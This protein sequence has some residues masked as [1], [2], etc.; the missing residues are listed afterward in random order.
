[1][2]THLI[3]SLGKGLGKIDERSK[4]LC[5]E[6]MEQVLL[7][8]A[9]QEQEGVQEWV[10]LVWEEWE[11]PEQEPVPGENAS[12]PSVERLPLMRLESPALTKNVL[13]V[14]QTW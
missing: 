14:E 12:V 11:A 3:T 5:Q 6:V 9:V 10:G 8:G 4:R 7:E 13:N 1:M 2:G